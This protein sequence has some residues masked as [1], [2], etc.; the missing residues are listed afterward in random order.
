MT[1][2]R[3]IE[4]L[5]S[6]NELVENF[7]KNRKQL[8]NK[9]KEMR[10]DVVAK[11]E[12]IKRQ[13]EPITK[14]IDELKDTIKSTSEKGGFFKMFER[15]S[16]VSKSQSEIKL[17][18]KSNVGK[19]GTKGEVDLADLQDGMLRLRNTQT[20]ETYET[21]LDEDLAEMLFKPFRNIDLDEISKSALVSYYEIMKIA[22]I[23]PRANNNKKIKQAKQAY[24]NV[25]ASQPQKQRRTVI[26]KKLLQKIKNH[27]YYK[28]LNDTQKQALDEATF[29]DDLEASEI[30]EKILIQMETDYQNIG[31]DEQEETKS[32]DEDMEEERG[33]PPRRTYKSK[34][35]GVDEETLKEERG[36]RRRSKLMK[37][38]SER[39]QRDVMERRRRKEDYKNFK[40]RQFEMKERLSKDRGQTYTMDKRKYRRVRQKGNGLM[41]FDEMIE[42]FYLLAQSQK[43]GN[44][45][46]EITEEM[47]DL[48]DNLL[49]KKVINKAEHKT[50]F[51]NYINIV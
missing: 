39:I 37:E 12:E 33:L 51:D 47:M 46:N 44:I 38:R 9:V 22:G 40:Y 8:K 34:E 25:N 31:R 4:D 29:A 24:Q 21:R 17:T 1:D 45:S 3:N 18:T 15:F 10:G 32:S 26:Q 7:V 42:R 13:T 41:S 36:D 50:L 28:Y 20:G 30:L 27:K 2:Y 35:Y 5:D 43:G 11:Q 48:I 19:L 23:S 6:F 14:S 49:V 16:G